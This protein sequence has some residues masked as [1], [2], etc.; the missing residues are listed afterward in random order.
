[1]VQSLTTGLA[2]VSSYLWGSNTTQQVT[3]GNQDSEPAP[4]L[5]E[6]I[7]ASDIVKE[8]FLFK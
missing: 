6:E 3:A 2:T 1:M 8:G 4:I 7:K 5:T